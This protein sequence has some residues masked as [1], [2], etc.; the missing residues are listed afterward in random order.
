MLCALSAG[1]RGS[2][3]AQTPPTQLAPVVT[4]GTRTP[5]APTTLGTFVETFTA[6]ELARRQQIS[7]KD[8]LGNAS[9]TPL[10]ASGANGALGS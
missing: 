9:G 8:A 7:L 4:L 5:S 6:A 2:L 10:F 1:S 3:R